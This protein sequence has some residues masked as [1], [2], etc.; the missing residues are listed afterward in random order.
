MTRTFARRMGHDILAGV[1]SGGMLLGLMNFQG[2]KP[3]NAPLPPGAINTFDASS[4]QTLMTAQAALNALKADEAQ[5]P[6]IAPYLNQAITDYNTAESAW[7]TYH[8]SGSNSAGLTA[9]LAQ[10]STDILKI[11]GLIPSTTAATGAAK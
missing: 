1:I 7:Q 3:A 6:Q 8:A 4:Y 10:L 9:A 5:A 2:C 11:E